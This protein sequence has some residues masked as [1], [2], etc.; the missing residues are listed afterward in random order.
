MFD[1]IILSIFNDESNF[2]SKLFIK[3]TLSILPNKFLNASYIFIY[4]I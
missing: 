3:L 2:F 4:I 1:F